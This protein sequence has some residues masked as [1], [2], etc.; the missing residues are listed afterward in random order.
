[1][2]V[3]HIYV[4]YVI[5]LTQRHY[6]AVTITALHQL[7]QWRRRLECVVRPS[8]TTRSISNTA[9]EHHCHYVWHWW[10]PSLPS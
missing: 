3:R 6:I 1:M 8:P 10:P 7:N 9:S 2:S 5:S 4:C